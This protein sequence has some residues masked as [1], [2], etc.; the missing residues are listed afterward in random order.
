M[1]I[2][3][4]TTEQLFSLYELIALPTKIAED[5][6]VTHLSTPFS[7]FRSVGATTCC[8]QQ[9]TYS[10]APEEAWGSVP[11][12]YHYTMLKRLAAKLVCFSRPR[13]KAA[14]P[15]KTKN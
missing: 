3:L 8:C 7:A 5:K 1:K 14:V 11:Q 12:T 4:K 6:F 10:S 9:P 13:E 2:P 15:G